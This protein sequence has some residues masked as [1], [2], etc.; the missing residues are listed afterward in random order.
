MK[1][2]ENCDKIMNFYDASIISW[3]RNYACVEMITDLYSYYEK[4]CHVIKTTLQLKD[5]FYT[6]FHFYVT[7]QVFNKQA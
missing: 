4:S 7:I 3:E 1:D 5:N 2:K 6:A